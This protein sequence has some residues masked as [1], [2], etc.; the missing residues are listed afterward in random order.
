[1][2]IT[3]THYVRVCAVAKKF[4]IAKKYEIIQTRIQKNI[5]RKS[6]KNL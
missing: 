2:Y 6:E 1:M 3:H 4:D 5:R